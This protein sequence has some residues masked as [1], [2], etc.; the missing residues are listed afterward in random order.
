M[1]RGWG[2]GECSERPCWLPGL[3]QV[4][5]T[6]KARPLG[7]TL[8]RTKPSEVQTPYGDCGRGVSSE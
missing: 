4:P 7:T 5:E 8:K 3:T 1:S 2:R 6:A